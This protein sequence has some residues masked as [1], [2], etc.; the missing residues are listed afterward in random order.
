MGGMIMLFRTLAAAGLL[1]SFLASAACT[2]QQPGRD[3]GDE[4]LHVLPGRFADEPVTKPLVAVEAYIGEED[5][6]LRK[7]EAR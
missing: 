2:S 7:L 6:F 3:P 5:D 4:D 1:L